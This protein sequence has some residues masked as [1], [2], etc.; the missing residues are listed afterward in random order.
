MLTFILY[1]AYLNLGSR[2]EKFV[3]LD[4]ISLSYDVSESDPSSLEAVR[5]SSASIVLT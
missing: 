4:V 1:T 2:M 5:K 3:M